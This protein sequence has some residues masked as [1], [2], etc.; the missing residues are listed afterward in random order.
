LKLDQVDQGLAHASTEAQSE[1][2]HHA[3]EWYAQQLLDHYGRAQVLGL[4]HNG[5]PANILADPR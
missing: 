3:A 5:V 1:A 4:L 2:A